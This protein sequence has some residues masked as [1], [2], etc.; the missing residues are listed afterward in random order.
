MFWQRKYFIIYFLKNIDVFCTSLVTST[1]SLFLSNS[2]KYSQLA[3]TH[4]HAWK[5]NAHD[6]VGHPINQHCYGHSTRPRPLR[7]QLRSDQPRYRPWANGEE[8]HE[9]ERGDHGEITHPVNHFL[10]ISKKLLSGRRM[11]FFP[12]PSGWY[13]YNITHGV[14]LVLGLAAGSFRWQTATRNPNMP[15]YTSLVT[16]RPNTRCGNQNRIMPSHSHLPM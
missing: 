10:Y 6:E 13:K 14:R 2:Q 7:E 16:Y 12:A 3:R 1:V 9:T 5:A 15:P 4:L 11:G 8:Y